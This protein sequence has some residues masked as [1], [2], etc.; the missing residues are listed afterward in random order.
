MDEPTSALSQHEVDMLFEVM[1][2]LREHG[3][4]V[5]YISHKLDEFRRSATVSPSC[6]TAAWSPK[7]R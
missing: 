5:V 3:V 1:A 6:A 7:R 2:D 4:T